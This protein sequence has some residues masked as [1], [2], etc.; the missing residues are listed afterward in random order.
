MKHV[1]QNKHQR[2]AHAAYL[3]I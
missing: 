2:F 3:H 1:L